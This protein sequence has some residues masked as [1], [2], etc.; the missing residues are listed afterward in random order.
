MCGIAT[1][2]CPVSEPSVGEIAGPMTQHLDRPAPASKGTRPWSPAGIEKTL[3]ADRCA[4]PGAVPESARRRRRA[5]R[6]A[7][8]SRPVPARTGGT[9]MTIQVG[10]KLPAANLK[11]LTADGIKDVPIAGSDPRQEGG[12]V[13][14]AGRLHADLLGAAPAG[15]LEQAGGA[16][17]QGR[18]H[19]RLRRGQRP[20]RAERLGQGA[21]TSTARSRCSPTAMPSSPRRSAST[22]TPAAS[23]SA[24]ARSAMR[25]WSTTASVK[26][27]LVEDVPSQ[28]EKSSAE[29]I[30]A[31]ALAG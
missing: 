8:E 4:S 3:A 25:W 27:L 14:R 11:R 5:R 7:P 12:A 16:Q 26:T 22:S 24:P 21:A 29:A 1:S 31:H 15:L 17:G 23:A 20:V 19:D 30:L 18:R 10:D 6:A 2:S 28:A 13:R 9:P